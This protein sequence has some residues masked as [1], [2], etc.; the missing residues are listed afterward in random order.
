MKA[1]THLSLLL[2]AVSI[3]FNL[4]AQTSHTVIVNSS[5]FSPANLT[6]S[7][8]DTVI[9][10]NSSGSHNVNGTTTTYP[11]NPESFGNAV[12]SGWTFSHKFNTVGLYDYR[13][14]VH[15]SVGMFG[16]ITVATAGIK[17]QTR[18][19]KFVS[20]YPN[21]AYNELKIK[22]EPE[23]NMSNSA[24]LIYDMNGNRVCEI[25]LKDQS[26]SIDLKHLQS[27]VYFYQLINSETKE[28]IK[29]DKLL[30]D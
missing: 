7:L 28:I 5:T 9:W 15:A 4:C 3:S 19:S 20:V 18:L 17:E 11:S 21:P 2:C 24:L 6:I 10:T 14:D 26:N 30:V 22:F 25:H 1:L 29:R 13:C 16:R 23:L 27:G 12:S 8:G